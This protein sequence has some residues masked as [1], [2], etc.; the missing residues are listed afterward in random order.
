MV[1]SVRPGMQKKQK[2]VINSLVEMQYVRSD[3]EFMRGNF[4]VKGD[5]IDIFPAENSEEA[6]R[7]EFFGDEIDRVCLIDPVTGK[8]N[9]ISKHEFIYPKSHYVIPKEKIESAIDRIKLEL[10][11]R[12]KYF[13]DNDKVVEAYRIEQRTNFDIEMLRETG[14][15]QGIENYSAVLSG[16]APGSTPYTLFDY[17]GDDFLVVIDESHVTV[18]QKNHLLKMDL[19]YRLHLIIDLLN[20][21]NGKKEQRMSYML[22]QHQQNMKKNILNV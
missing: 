20:L 15:C 7:L 1:L 4:R 21:R 8:V 3:M 13:K 5:I 11:D 10:K 22:A 9:A 19:D 17:L 2:D 12:I 14:F 18:P 16:R 6:I